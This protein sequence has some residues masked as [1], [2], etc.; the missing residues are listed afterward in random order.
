VAAAAPADADAEAIEKLRA[1][2]YVGSSEAASA[3]EAA[4][5]SGSTRTAGS[6]NNEALL[7]QAEGKRERAV[8]AFEKALEI[9]PNLASAAWNLSDLLHGEKRDLDRSDAL[10][11]TAFAHGLPDGTKLLVARAI[12]YQRG[13]DGERSLRLMQRASEVQSDEPEVWLFLGRYQVG[14]GRCREAVPSF[15]KATSLAPDNPAA[16][17]SLGL[18]QMCAGNEADAAAALRKSLAL[19]PDQPRVR[20]F[21]ARISRRSS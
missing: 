12:A 16:F 21:L 18:A 2:G 19:D 15:Q 9:D 20:A 7:L 8:A 11:V 10:L 1:L 3:P 17:A 6:H 5:R 4:R 14:A 13:G